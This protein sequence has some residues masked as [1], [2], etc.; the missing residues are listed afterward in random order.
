MKQNF[1][2]CASEEG[3][4][5]VAYTEWGEENQS[6]EA[7]ICVH[8][9]TRNS[10]DFDALASYLSFH[11][12]HV[13]C[14]D[15]VGRGDSDWLKD[16]QHY[17][18]KRYVE[19]M[20]VMIG[21]TGAEHINWIGTSM[22]GLIGIMLAAL[23]NSPIR[24]LILNDVG[25]QVPVHA[26]WQMAKYVGRDPEFPDKKAAKTHYK[27]IYAEFGNLSESQWDYFTSHSIIQLD[28]G[29]YM[30]KFDPGIHDFRFTWQSFKE[31][32][33]SP[34]KAFEGVF[35]DVDLWKLW[36]NIR[37]PVYLIRGKRS[38]VLLPEHIKKMRLTHPGLEV[39]EI[40]DAGHAPALLGVPEQE[41]IR[42]WLRWL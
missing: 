22:G 16:D 40:E 11:Q 36:R 34:H 15:I 1:I 35:F 23:P 14:P 33:Y 21:R 12:S 38:T 42:T 30:S 7:V 26:L 3:F 4:H 31:V 2:L 9:L 18:F 19:D 20:N 5:R 28:N 25:P 39:L 10:R 13:F 27:K 41:R 8:G 29:K 37:C 32:F 17:N 6:S 24:R